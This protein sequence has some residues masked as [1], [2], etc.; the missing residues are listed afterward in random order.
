MEL[1]AVG[2]DGTTPLR[3]EVSPA[4]KLD[5]PDGDIS[6][7]FSAANTFLAVAVAIPCATMSVLTGHALTRDGS[8]VPGLAVSILEHPEWGTATTQ[9]DGLYALAVASA[10]QA[11]VEVSPAARARG[12]LRARGR[13]R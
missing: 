1:V 12:P 9:A 8:G 10:I 6:T 4:T 5:V 7:D 11:S 3:A 13:R 2:A